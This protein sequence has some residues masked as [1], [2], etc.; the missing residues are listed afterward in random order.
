MRAISRSALGERASPP[1]LGNMIVAI[2]AAF[3]AVVGGLIG[4]VRYA[5][6]DPAKWHVDPL[7]ATSPSSPNSYRIGPEHGA[8]GAVEA[9]DAVAPVW[10]V[11]V[12]ELAS[13]FD[14][15]VTADARVDVIAGSAADGHVT[16][17]QRSK[18]MAYPDYISVRFIDLGDGTSTLAAFSRARYGYSDLGVNKQRLERWVGDVTA[19][20]G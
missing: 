3:V 4:Y 7:T 6:H 16:Y 13:T 18:T 1:T 15:L 14:S 11:S 10:S 8:H 17:V 2:V 9:P 20:L 19:Q 5:G 12:D